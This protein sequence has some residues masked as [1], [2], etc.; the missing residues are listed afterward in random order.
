RRSPL[1]H[2]IARP[3]GRASFRTPYCV[4][5]LPRFAAREE[6]A[7]AV[8][9]SSPAKRGRG[10]GRRPVEGAAPPERL[11]V[12]FAAQPQPLP[13]DLAGLRQG[14]AEGASRGKSLDCIRTGI[15]S[16]NF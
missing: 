3:E 8:S 14:S 6:S 2:A 5:P 10:T 13:A 11:A 16:G 7:A 9:L 1:R 4:V 15:F 12:T